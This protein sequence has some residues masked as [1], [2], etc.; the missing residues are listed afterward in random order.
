[1]ELAKSQEAKQLIQIGIHDQSAIL[2][3]FA[4]PPATPKS[5]VTV[6]QRAF[7]STMEDAQFLAEMKQAKLGVDPVDG[8]EI[9]KIVAGMSKMEAGLA[10]KL[11]E[12]LGIK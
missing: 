12:I 6:M 8:G 5:T 1:M 11:R 9:E 10:A 4:L 7:R 2:R 3:P